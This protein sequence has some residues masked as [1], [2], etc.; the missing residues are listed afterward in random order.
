MYLSICGFNHKTASLQDREYFQIPRSELAETTAAYK[1]FTGADEAAIAATCNRVEFYRVVKQKN[2]HYEELVRFYQSR[3]VEQAPLLRDICYSRQ[4][5]TAARHLFRVASGLDSLVLGEDQILHQVKEAYSAACAVNGPGKI[6]HKL[7]HMAF[8]IAKQVRSETDISTGPRNI[9][10]A[11]LELLLQK[12]EGKLPRQ[13]MVIGVNHMTEIFLE[14]L[15]KRNIPAI[16][17][18]RT[19]LN[20]QEI[21]Q[22]F[23][24]P[25]YPL[26]EIPNL[27][28]QCSAVF[29]TAASQNYL[30]VKEH[31]GKED[32]SQDPLYFID[33]AVPR[34]VDPELGKIPGVT[35]LDLQDLKRHLDANTARRSRDIPTAEE[36]IERQVSAYSLWRSKTLSQEKLIKL[37][38]ALDAARQRELDKIY[39]SFRKSDIKTLNA[40]SL[41]IMR[42]F[43]KYA[44]YL[45]NEDE[46]PLEGMDFNPGNIS[47]QDDYKA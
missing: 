41:N 39:I 24:I 8:Q 20:A 27:L 10:G 35:L 40:F 43:L 14:H 36:L 19:L 21:A 2:N 7:F 13:A 26:E 25:A 16:L 47:T 34:N 32:R 23:G 33:I 44:P 3:S 18:N 22:S 4:G 15:T 29:T 42:E 45:L 17:V 46:T 30:V 31:L 6:L 9:P 38:E 28:A 37:K 11:A 12:I 1:N 5:T